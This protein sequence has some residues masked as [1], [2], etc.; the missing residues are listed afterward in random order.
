MGSEDFIQEVRLQMEPF[1]LYPG[2]GMCAASG[3]CALSLSFR[4][5]E[6]GIVPLTSLSC[7]Q[8]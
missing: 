7:L 6:M 5:C 4:F 1:M 3:F 2:R 8:D